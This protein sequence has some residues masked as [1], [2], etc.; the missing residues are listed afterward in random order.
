VVLLGDAAHAIVPF[1]GQGA[2]A[3]FEDCESLTDALAAHGDNIAAAISAYEL[4]RKR[5][6]DAI[7]EMAL[8]NFVEMRD[9]TASRIFKW[10]KKLDH[11]LHGVAPNLFTPLYDMVSFSTIPYA[12]ALAKSHEQVRYFVFFMMCFTL[13]I[14]FVLRPVGLDSV[15]SL[16]LMLVVMFIAF[17]WSNKWANKWLKEWLNRRKI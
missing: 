5:N 12:D 6:A 3:S 15:I 10:K 14:R 16:T 13:I 2:N 7:A 9:K 11:F 4:D 1:F 17:K 8:T